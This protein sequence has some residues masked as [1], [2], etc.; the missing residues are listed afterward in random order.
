MKTTHPPLARAALLALLV[1]SGAPLF[2]QDASD[3]LSSKPGAGTQP[4]SEKNVADSE[5]DR[6]Q[7]E[8]RR[9]N[10]SQPV[11]VTTID[12]NAN[13]SLSSQT[14]AMTSP[15]FDQTTGKLL[16]EI[17]GMDVHNRQGDKLGTIRDV[18]ID[19][20]SGKAAYFVVSAG[21]LVGMN[22]TLRAVPIQ[23]LKHEMV[24]KDERIVLDLDKP[25]WEQAP[26][27]ERGRITS[28]PQDGASANGSYTY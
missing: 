27:L 3:S 6:S 17:R 4:P 20:H 18:V 8:L 12:A 28:L 1:G 25:R 16:S 26:A 7:N 11:T 13:T 22:Q 9:R 2:A 5:H 24:G 21:G 10:S 19:S 14:P 15:P 23:A